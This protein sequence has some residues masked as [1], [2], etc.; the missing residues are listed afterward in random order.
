MFYLLKKNY[1]LQVIAL[2][3][4]VATGCFFIFAHPIEV[5]GFE[6][7]L[8]RLDAAMLS[9]IQTHPTGIK[10]SLFLILLVQMWLL[11]R[12]IRVSGFM[13]EE[14]VA[15][16]AIALALP[17]GAGIFT[18][19]SPVWI[20]NLVILIVLNLNLNAQGKSSP[21]ATLL[22]G[23][24]IGIGSFFDYA[25][26]VV[27][28]YYII[29]LLVNRLE[30]IKSVLVAL[31]GVALTYI[32]LFAY[33]VFAWSGYK[34]PELYVFPPLSFPMF[35]ATHLSIYALIA[36]ILFII[37]SLYIIIRLKV[38]YDNKLIALRQ[39]YLFL[40]LLFVF[41]LAII[42]AGNFAFPYSLGYLIIPVACFI[43]AI[44]P[45]HGFSI[46]LEIM[47]VLYVAAF[48]VMGWA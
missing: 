36:G 25:A 16:L 47:L 14:T 42:L 9:A 37:L 13:D 2:V 4:V 20:T 7:W 21:T 48:I 46:P 35:T 10:S 3:A 5:V 6:I 31:C 26:A 8:Q 34:F 18:P 24:A 40:C 45:S 39:R 11:Y 17:L 33:Q 29:F 44:T 32:Y 22:S 28:L 41:A 38:Q 1:L 27:L 43:V 30:R 23:V 15:P 19:F 12:Y